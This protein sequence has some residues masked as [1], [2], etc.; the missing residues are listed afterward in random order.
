M[1]TI[2]INGL[3][4]IFW[5]GDWKWGYN[6]IHHKEVNNF[7]PNCNANIFTDILCEIGA[8]GFLAAAEKLEEGKYYFF[9]EI[10]F[11]YENV[12]CVGGDEIDLVIDDYK[13]R[14]TKQE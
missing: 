1:E 4:D 8:E 12:F 9:A 14:T 7:Y 13:V 6:L 10:S 5:D 3:I 11:Y 2:Y